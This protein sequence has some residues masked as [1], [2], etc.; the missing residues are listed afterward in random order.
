MKTFEADAHKEGRIAKG[1]ERAAAS[2]AEH[3]RGREIN[4]PKHGP[5]STFMKSFGVGTYPTQTE[6][7]SLHGEWNCNTRRGASLILAS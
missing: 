5:C 4:G 7:M 3:M 2:F 6:Q 1:E